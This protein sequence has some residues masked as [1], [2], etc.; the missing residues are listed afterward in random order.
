MEKVKAMTEK[1]IEEFYDACPLGYC[2]EEMRVFDVES[3]RYV[4][5]KMQYIELF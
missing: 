3:F 5:V 4:T 2:V 1:Q